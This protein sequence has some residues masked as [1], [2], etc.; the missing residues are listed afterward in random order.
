MEQEADLFLD[1]MRVERGL[2]GN[3]LE[4]YR[5]DLN[6]LIGFLESRRIRRPQAIR[7][8]D[9]EAYARFLAAEGLGP[10]SAARHLSSLRSFVKFLQAEGRLKGDLAAA[11]ALPKKPLRLPAFL[12]ATQVQALLEAGHTRRDLAILELLYGAGLRA[13]E[14]CG[15]RMEDVRLEERYL[16]ARGKGMK[17]RVVPIGRAAVARVR[18]YLPKRPAGPYLFAGRFAG[19]PLRRES[20][21]HLVQRAARLSGV[22]QRLY[23]H[24]L[25][26]TFATHMIE[27]GAEL[28]SVQELLGHASVATT[29]IYTHVDPKRL[30]GI[31]SRFHPRA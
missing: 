27:G 5:R 9:I 29:Q 2:A 12:T 3:T 6:R 17:E 21:W 7:P 22:R 11:I 20:I 19:R 25:R 14:L 30:R 28:R 4:A 23:P 31:H 10:L 8:R 15:L 13:S 26:H 18:E 1:A 16:R 24:L